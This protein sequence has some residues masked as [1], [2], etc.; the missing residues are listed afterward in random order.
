VACTTLRYYYPYLACGGGPT[1]RAGKA[2]SAELA[3]GPVVAQLRAQPNPATEQVSLTYTLPA[4]QQATRL[5]LRDLYR[6]NVVA[7]Q[8]LADNAN[9][10]IE[11]TVR[12]LP[13]GLYACALL[14][15]GRPAAT[16]K[17]VV[18]H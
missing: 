8:P 9:G 5:E 10:S 18:Q 15:Q 2:S 4:G 17:L 1:L 6:G 12:T 16:C 11:L 14:V 3:A 7:S 13:A